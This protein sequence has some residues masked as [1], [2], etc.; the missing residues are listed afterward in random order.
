MDEK[1]SRDS[2]AK[3]RVAPPSNKNHLLVDMKRRRPKSPEL[4][5]LGRPDLKLAR[6]LSLFAGLPVSMSSSLALGPDTLLQVT[7]GAG[8]IEWLRKGAPGQ[9]SLMRKLAYV[10]RK[11]HTLSPGLR[12]LV[13]TE[14]APLFK[15]LPKAEIE[16]SL[17][18]SEYTISTPS[19]PWELFLGGL[20]ESG[21]RQ[22]ADPLVQLCHWMIACDEHAFYIENLMRSGQTAAAETHLVPLIGQSHKAW[23]DLNPKLA[24]QAV[25]AIEIPLM[26]LA[27]LEYELAEAEAKPGTEI[28]SSVMQLLD[29]TARP[30]GHWLRDVCSFAD[31]R[32]LGELST[33][34][35]RSGAKYRGSAVSHERL[36][37]WA[38]SKEVAMPPQA[39]S[40]VLMA[41][42]ST[43]KRDMLRDKF[44]VARLLTFLCDLVLSSTIG[45]APAWKDAQ[46]QIRSRY[47]QA[48]QSQAA[49]RSSRSA[50]HHV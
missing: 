27:R 29:H 2:A 42:S 8:I 22:L 14:F 34:L 5:V 16:R 9:V 21:S 48:F 19:S 23:I 41:V 36:K 31:C 38:R 6:P 24:I 7:T 43:S 30:I 10:A 18:D 1:T 20:R 33:A 44:G 25:P 49:L 35:L 45:A 32:N 46:N 50:V 3:G 13:L 12:K 39:V 15:V 47:E 17:D 28:R 40:A 26:A 37:K 11:E 4:V